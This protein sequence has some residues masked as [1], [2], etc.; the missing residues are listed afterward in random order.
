MEPPAKP[1]TAKELEETLASN[2]DKNDAKLT[3]IL[4]GLY[5][6]ERITVARLASLKAAL[7]GSESRDALMALADAS[8]FE[9]LPAEDVPNIKSPDLAEQK[10]MVVRIGNYL[11]KVLPSLP[12]L[13]AAR[14]TTYFEDHP[15]R[16]QSSWAETPSTIRELS[17]VENDPD[18]MKLRWP[19]HRAGESK[20]Q[21]S[22]VN[23]KESTM[24][25][26][27]EPANY[28]SRLTTAGEFGPIL[29]GVIMDAAHSNLAWARWDPSADGPLA[30]FRFDAPKENSHFSLR[31]GGAAKGQNPFA[32]YSGTFAIRPADGTIV[33][34]EVVAHPSPGD[35]LVDAKLIVEYG[36]VEI[37]GH[38]YM[39]PVHGVALSRVPLQAN[40]RAGKTKGGRFQTHLNDIVF[41]Q[42]QAFR[43]ES[44]VFE[45]VTAD[46]SEP[47]RPGANA[48]PKPITDTPGAAG[49]N[50]NSPAW[51]DSVAAVTAP[52]AE[53]AAASVPAPI[54]AKTAQPLP[55]PEPAATSG[56]MAPP[57]DLPLNRPT[58]SPEMP[59]VTETSLRMNVDL[60]LVPVV[61]RDAKSLAAIGGLTKEDF[62]IFDNKKLQ[63]ITSF[64]VENRAGAQTAADGPS[65]GQGENIAPKDST[66]TAEPRMLVYLFDDVHLTSADLLPLRDAAL[67]NMGSLQANDLA[68]LISTSGQ[69]VVS[70]TTDRQKLQDAIMKIRAKPLSG[71]TLAECPDISYYMALNMLRESDD[72]ETMVAAMQETT[73]CRNGLRNMT[74]QQAQIGQKVALQMVK[75]AA[76]RA[77][78]TGE[79]ES[80]T[81]ITRA[82]EVIDWL[83]KMPGKKSVILISPG[84]LLEPDKQS[85]IADIIDRAIRAEVAI[86]A[87]DVRGLGGMNP[88]REIQKAVTHDFQFAQMASRMATEEAIEIP[89]VM[90]E[91]SRGTGGE[92]ITNTGD[93]SWAFQRLLTPPDFTYVLGFRPAKR[94]GKHHDLTVKLHEKKGMELQSRQAYFVSKQ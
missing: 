30:V 57:A 91:L 40:S 70:F 93:F 47:A 19:L 67:K 17:P 63:E 69:V 72:A 51:T 2:R 14:S 68:A 23:G 20:I 46:L 31:Q 79:L 5:L 43:S 62:Q 89:H 25:G 7:P 34:L 12:N 42:Y 58:S 86:S 24:K 78:R 13:L 77:Q 90:E 37:G 29:Y 44:R 36:Q 28:A 65:P 45:A 74:S 48:Q 38:N 49:T 87:I 56:A 81:A 16:P 80:R 53:T 59:A 1:V 11:G 35:P 41:D 64:M 50:P 71:T 4:S 52:V 73:N 60:V 92:F 66:S 54:E 21:V 22:N 84:F 26:A 83:A 75:L 33:W 18:S 39:C 85:D 8:A 6:T 27:L 15:S 32:A 9:A 94:D 88:S 10:Q 82:R 76:R 3:S 61:V 55:N